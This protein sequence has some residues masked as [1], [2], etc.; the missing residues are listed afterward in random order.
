MHYPVNGGD[1]RGAILYVHPFAE[2]MNRS[3]RMAALQARVFSKAGFEV[4]QIDMLGCGDSSG[5]FG[6]A[7]WQNWIDDIRLGYDWVRLRT[8]QPITLWGLRTG[9][10]LA[11]SAAKTL[12]EKVNFLF[13]QPT[14]SGS[15]YLTQFI[16][17]KVA[18]EIASGQAKGVAEALRQQL[19]A[20]EI[21]EVAGYTVAPGLA[22]GLGSAEMQLDTVAG[23][24]VLLELT[25][26]EKVELSPIAQ[27]KIADWQ[28]LGLQVSS[29]VVQGPAFWQTAEIEDAPN[30]LAASLTAVESWQ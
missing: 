9:C 2:E 4:L 13:W 23:N 1:A 22:Q 11:V 29:K 25:T 6:D 20:G 10:L 30:L 3:R 26:R 5:D 8:K 21:I 24:V 18:S 16:R 12:P 27:R 7:S 15:Q 14:F 19:S 28:L 17:L